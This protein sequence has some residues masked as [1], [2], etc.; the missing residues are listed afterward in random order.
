MRGSLVPVEQIERAILLVRGHKVKLDADLA[1]LYGV[2]TRALIPALKR[3]MARFP[4]D[5]RFHLSAGEYATLRSQF[6]T[7]KPEGRGG[8]RSNRM[9]TL[10]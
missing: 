10:R 7:S 2:E 8:R 4:K 3:S 5:F 9:T 6:V 1:A